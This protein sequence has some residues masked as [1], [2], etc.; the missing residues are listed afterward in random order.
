MGKKIGTTRPMTLDVLLPPFTESFQI[1][2]SDSITQWHYDQDGSY[3]PD[4]AITPLILTPTL[5]VFDPE[6]K[7][8]Y[9]P[10]FYLVRWYLLN[11][12]TGNYDT[13]ITNTTD[14]DVDYVVLSS[15]ALKVKKNVTESSP[16]NLLCIVQY[17]DPRNAGK[18]Y[19]CTAT[20]QLTTSKDT[21][22]TSP[23]IEIDKEA[24]VLYNPFIDGYTTDENGVKHHNFTF[25]ATARLGEE[26]LDVTSANS[27]Y[28][29]K[30]Y[31][32]GDGITSET[33]IDA[34]EQVSGIAVAKF[35]CYVSG[36]NTPTLVVDAMMT[37]N[38]TIIARIVNTSTNRT[39]PEKCLRRLTW[40]GFK[41]DATTEAIDSGAVKQDTQSKTLRNI[42][43]LRNR[44]LDQSVVNEN[45][46]QDW[47]FRNAANSVIQ[48]LGASPN[49]IVPGEKLHAQESALVYSELS[50]YEGYKVVTHDGKVITNG[51]KVVVCR[52]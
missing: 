8:T 25:V 15:G 26:V 19:K 36:Q 50:L 13:E 18:T 32:I 20:K 11:S 3:L 23:T 38:V 42:V 45:F 28:R 1:V 37:D 48:Y 27:P 49:V 30:W 33:L 14:G 16:V 44:T 7:L 4:R 12:S 51:G 43:T 6:T 9:T 40:D 29:I 35:P 17:I 39:Y 47:Y 41:V 46:R 2:A 24:T 5:S 34:T 22:I 31:A 52:I 21:S 10:S